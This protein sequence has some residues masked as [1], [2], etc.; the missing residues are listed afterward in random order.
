MPAIGLG[1]FRAPPERART[2]VRTA[3]DLDYRHIDT[4]L[5]HKSA[6]GQGSPFPGADLSHSFRDG[7]AE[8]GVAVQDGDA[9]VEF[10]DLTVE[11]SCHE[12]LA[13]Q[14]RFA[15]LRFTQCIFVSTRLRRWYPLHRRQSARPR[16]F[17]VRRASLRATAPAVTFFHGFAF[18]RG[19]MTA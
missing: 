10:G 19:G 11:V 18:W 17:D 2:A 15:D 5:L 4:A 12:P 14:F 1:V 6:I 16:H 7:Y 9:D 8:C 13:Q 3:L